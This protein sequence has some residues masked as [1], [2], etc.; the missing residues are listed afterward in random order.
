M[1]KLIATLKTTLFY[2]ENSEDSDWSNLSVSDSKEI[3]TIEL[4]KIQA[5]I[6]FD[7]HELAV[8]FAATSNIQEI[9]MFNGWSEKYLE[10][11][12]VVD[13]LTGR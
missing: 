1:D 4:Q 12:E 11:A 2:L 7:K 13:E 5:G 10:L 6:G 3:L 8:Q 9:A